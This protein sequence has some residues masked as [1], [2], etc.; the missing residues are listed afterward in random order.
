MHVVHV[1]STYVATRVQVLHRHT[2]STARRHGIVE[3]QREG[4]S[5]YNHKNEINTLW[6][7]CGERIDEI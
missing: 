4:S 5:M 2:N 7:L 1:K 6:G 3:R